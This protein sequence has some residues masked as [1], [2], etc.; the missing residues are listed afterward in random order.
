MGCSL[1]GCCGCVGW[2]AGRTV[3]MVGPWKVGPE[4]VGARRE[5][6]PKISR[7]FFSLPPEISFFLLWG[8]FS[9]NFGGVFE[10]RGAQMCTFGVLWLSCEAPAAPKPPEFDT[11]TRELQTCTFEGPSLQE[12][13][14]NSTRRHPE[15]EEK[16][17][18]CGGR[19][20]TKTKFWAVRGRAVPRRAVRE[21]RSKPNLETNTHT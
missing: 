14:Q 10:G 2:W 7:F 18:F 21:G 19:G 20:K 15:R 11:T 1:W 9:W 12:H 4:G 8:V 17:E 5:G 16:N 6:R 13:H 3:G